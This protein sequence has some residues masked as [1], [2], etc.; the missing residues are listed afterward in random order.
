[1]NSGKAPTNSQSKVKIKIPRSMSKSTGFSP[2]TS[3]PKQRKSERE[4]QLDRIYGILDKAIE[5]GW[6]IDFDPESLSTKELKALKTKDV[7]LKGYYTD[8]ETG[9]AYYGEEAYKFIRSRAAKKAAE[10]RRKKKEEQEQDDYLNEALSGE[11]FVIDRFMSIFDEV[12]T[13]SDTKRYYR[14]KPDAVMASQQK[15]LIVLEKLDDAINQLGTNAVAQIISDNY[16]EIE[17]AVD[18]LVYGYDLN[19]INSGFYPII[20]I[21]NGGIMTI[22]DAKRLGEIE[23]T[24]FPTY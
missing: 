18:H 24:D 22:E 12:R 20:R 10:T 11:D 4:K 16:G 2:K 3:T 5:D 7:K 19:E 14:R 17:Q 23:D 1:M 9:E 21:L 15:S 13:P 8:A 6:T